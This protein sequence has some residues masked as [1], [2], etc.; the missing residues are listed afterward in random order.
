M[1]HDVVVSKILAHVLTGGNTDITQEV[2]EEDMLKLEHDGFME[3]CKTEATRLRIAH[4]L[5]TSK[6]LR[7]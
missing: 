7:N 4:M 6:P 1:P 5:E 3:L 2:T